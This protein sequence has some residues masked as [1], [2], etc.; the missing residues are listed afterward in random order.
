MINILLNDAN[1]NLSGKKELIGRAARA[2]EEYTLPRLK[3]DWDIDVLFEKYMY[4]MILSDDMIG[5]RVRSRDFVEISIRGDGVTEDLLAEIL[6]FYLCHAARRGKNDEFERTLFYKLVDEGIA[7]FFEAEFAATRG[8]KT[9]F[10]SEV[11][12]KTDEE[13]E[14]MLNG[15]LDQ[16][17][18]EDYDYGDIFIAN[19]GNSLRW[20]GYALGYYLVKK[21]LDNTGKKIEDAYVDSFDSFKEVL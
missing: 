19:D 16:L 6:V 18:S 20:S 3:I 1:D 10:I 12:S 21:Y 17:D 7:T 11:L 4:D 15:L 8:E 9:A 13:N 5:G 2:A 14:Q